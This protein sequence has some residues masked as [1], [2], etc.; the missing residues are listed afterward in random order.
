VF[1]ALISS[2]PFDDAAQQSGL[3]SD[4]GSNETE[5]RSNA[6]S[7]NRRDC[8]QHTLTF[9]AQASSAE[10]IVRG[11]VSG[12][13]A[14]LTNRSPDRITPGSGPDRRGLRSLAEL[15]AGDQDLAPI[16]LRS[17]SVSDRVQG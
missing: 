11:A 1:L 14:A 5:R 8:A 13:S 4:A 16:E 7:P 6:Q 15:T 9:D 12:A 17:C 3:R 10:L 2:L